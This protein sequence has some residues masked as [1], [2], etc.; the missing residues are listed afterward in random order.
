MW[1]D[2]DT[3]GR[4]ERDARGWGHKLGLWRRWGWSHGGYKTEKRI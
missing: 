4:E 3:K 2:E 1:R